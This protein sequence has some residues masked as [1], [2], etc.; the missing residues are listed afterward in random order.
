MRYNIH[1]EVDQKSILCFSRVLNRS[2]TLERFMDTQ[3]FMIHYD[4]CFEEKKKQPAEVTRKQVLVYCRLLATIVTNNLV[5]YH[6]VALPTPHLRLIPWPRGTPV[7]VE[8]LPPLKFFHHR[9]A[10][11]CTCHDATRSIPLKS[12]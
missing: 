3:S 6:L 9:R 10:C 7:R 5:L 12:E 11:S 4:T 1:E 2:K 8:C